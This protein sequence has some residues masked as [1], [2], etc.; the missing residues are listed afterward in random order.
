MESVRSTPIGSTMLSKARERQIRSLRQ[1]KLRRRAGL[2]LV[3]GIRA[4]SDTLASSASVRYAVASPDLAHHPGGE[5]LAHTLQRAAFELHRVGSDVLRALSDTESPQGVL[6]VTEEPLPELGE[7]VDE[8]RVLVLDGVQD[9]GNVG[10]IV[11]TA[12]AFGLD[13]V[14]ALAG[15][16][17]L[18]S[19]KAVR[20]AAGATFHVPSVH[21]TADALQ[22]WTRAHEVPILVAD[23]SGTP[24]STLSSRDGSAMDR[25]ALILGREGGGPG[26]AMRSAADRVVAIPM[27]GGG[28]SLNVAV[29]AGILLYSL[30]SASE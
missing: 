9:P 25:W 20:A 18:W 12:R 10:T 22:R 21:L 7:P 24:V 13:A 29:S 19:P 28:D 5:E 4:V 23:A 2:V 17:D 27:L 16:A 6:L 14:I 26:E 15:T 11:R 1:S 3:E 30:T 8:V